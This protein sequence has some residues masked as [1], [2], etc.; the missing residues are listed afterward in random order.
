MGSYIGTEHPP[1]LPV[2]ASHWSNWVMRQGVTCIV[3]KDTLLHSGCGLV[4]S[5]LSWWCPTERPPVWPLYCSNLTVNTSLL[6]FINTLCSDSMYCIRNVSR[7]TLTHFFW[8]VLD[9]CCYTCLTVLSTYS[10]GP[11]TQY[12]HPLTNWKLKPSPRSYPHP[13]PIIYTHRM[14]QENYAWIYHS[15]QWCP[16]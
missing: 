8:T 16:E 9:T 7:P 6:L 12:W 13:H 2:K 3:T 11:K 4:A 14:G 10:S 1:P 15:V 5:S